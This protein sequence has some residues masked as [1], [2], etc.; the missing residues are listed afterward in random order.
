MVEHR[1][2]HYDIRGGGHAV[3]QVAPRGRTVLIGDAVHNAT[4][5]LGMGSDL[6]VNDATCLSNGLGAL[7][8]RAGPQ[9]ST[10]DIAKRV[11]AAY[12]GA[13]RS[14]ANVVC[15]APGM[16]AGF[17][18]MGKWYSGLVKLVF[19]WIPASLKM[20][21]FSVFD[22]GALMLDFLSL[23]GMSTA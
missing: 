8:K 11:S 10:A 9:P 17:E 4:A 20:R 19:G 7:L 15:Q 16:V 1:R 12:E 18:I 2:S 13:Q 21:I 3:H 5:H 6:C 23:P 14:R 22:N